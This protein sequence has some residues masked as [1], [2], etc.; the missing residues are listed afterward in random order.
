VC[1]SAGSYTTIAYQ[2]WREVTPSFLVWSYNIQDGEGKEAELKKFVKERVEPYLRAIPETMSVRTFIRK[3]GLG[4][5]PIFETWIEIP[6]LAYLDAHLELIK[7]EE[8]RKVMGGLLSFATD[9]NSTI[10]MLLE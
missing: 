10:R 2:Q 1:G 9:F 4:Q 6:N 5:R 8:H 3:A 7:T